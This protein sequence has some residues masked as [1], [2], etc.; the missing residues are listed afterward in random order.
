M[1]ASLQAS[2]FAPTWGMSQNSMTPLPQILV[3][4]WMWTV[5]YSKSRPDPNSSQVSKKYLM[6]RPTYG[7][8][9]QNDNV[10]F[11][12]HHQDGQ[13]VHDVSGRAEEGAFQAD[14]LWNIRV[15]FWCVLPEK[16]NS[17]LGR[18]CS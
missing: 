6:H 10:E 7:E 8:K 4:V 17:L 15:Y 5:W 16:V 12:S 1:G 14:V 18:F 11:D 2:I 9:M 3:W 13:E